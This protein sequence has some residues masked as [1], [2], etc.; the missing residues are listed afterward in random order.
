MN[1]IKWLILDV[2]GI[3]TD[4]RLWFDAQGEAIKCFHVHDGQGLKELRQHGIDVGII[5]GRD[6][7]ALRARLRELAID[8]HFLGVKDKLACYQE[9]KAQHNLTDS[10]IA[11]M[12]DDTPDLAVMQQVGFAI[13]VPNAVA[14]IRAVAHHCTAASGGQGAVREACE[15]L[16]QHRT[17][18]S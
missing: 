11:Y 13:T 7:Q 6:C 9:F 15:Y 16:I 17:A 14:A 2:D 8:C 4:G 3:L 12:G 10:D 18:A 1:P 5:S